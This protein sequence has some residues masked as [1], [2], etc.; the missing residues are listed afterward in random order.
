MLPIQIFFY[1][2]V[3][4]SPGLLRENDKQPWKQILAND[5]ILNTLKN[6]NS[7]GS[8][9]ANKLPWTCKSA[10]AKHE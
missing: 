5:P 8:L 9:E 3:L 2:S 10:K 1:V 6:F 4:L 7:G